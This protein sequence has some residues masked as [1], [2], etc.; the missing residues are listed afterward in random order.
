[1][2]LQ[3]SDLV[4]RQRGKPAITIQGDESVIREVW[5]PWLNSALEEETRKAF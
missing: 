3:S 5:D 2:L 4:D 1:M